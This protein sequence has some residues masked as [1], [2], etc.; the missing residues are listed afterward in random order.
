[1]LPNQYSEFSEAGPNLVDGPLQFMTRR[2]FTLSLAYGITKRTGCATYHLGD[3]TIIQKRHIQEYHLGFPVSRYHCRCLLRAAKT[4]LIGPRGLRTLG[5]LPLFSYLLVLH[6]F[7]TNALH[8]LHW[9]ED[10]SHTKSACYWEFA[11]YHKSSASPNGRTPFTTHK[12]GVKLSFPFR[13]ERPGKDSLSV[14]K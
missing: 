12:T 9:L 11:T 6:I 13:S 10:H 14:S 2:T 1:M 4:Y 3:T 7:L 5:S 8:K